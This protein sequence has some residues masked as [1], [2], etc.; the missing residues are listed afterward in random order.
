MEPRQWAVLSLENFIN[1]SVIFNMC[2]CGNHIL[3]AGHGM[4]MLMAKRKTKNDELDSI[5][6]L[7]LVTYLILGSLWLKFTDGATTQ[8]PIPVGF[9][10]GLVLASHDHIQLDR[11]IGFAVL[12]VAMLVGLWAPFGVYVNI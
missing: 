10:I 11:K 9:L 3:F 2:M 12:L 6:F 1:H 5:Y 8:V 7:K 4:I